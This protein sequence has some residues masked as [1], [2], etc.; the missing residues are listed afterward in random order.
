V[1]GRVL[2]PQ[3]DDGDLCGGLAAFDVQRQR[4]TLHGVQISASSGCADRWIKAPRSELRPAGD[5]V[6]AFAGHLM[7]VCWPWSAPGRR[8]TIQG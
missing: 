6:E 2:D 3:Q 5:A 8:R 7:R 4:C 1:V